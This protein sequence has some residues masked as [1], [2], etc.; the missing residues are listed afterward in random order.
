MVLKPFGNSVDVEADVL[1]RRRS[2]FPARKKWL[3]SLTL[4]DAD[5]RYSYAVARFR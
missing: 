2:R 1:R 3:V 5:V 4:F